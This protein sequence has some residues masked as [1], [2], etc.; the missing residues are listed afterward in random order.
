MLSIL[1]IINYI[2]KDEADQNII[3][4]T[5]RSKIIFGVASILKKMHNSNVIFRDVKLQKVGLGENL[6]STFFHN[7]L[8]KIVKD[9]S[10]MTQNIGT[11][12]VMAPEM[13]M[14]GADTYNFPIDVY[15]YGVMLYSMFVSDFKMGNKKISSKR[16]LKK[17][18]N[19]KRFD[20]SPKI[21]DHYWDLINECWEQDPNDRPTF[22]EIVEKL[23]SDKFA[24]EEFGIKTN[25]DELHEYQ[26]LI[27]N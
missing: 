5:I 6:E 4:P 21:P 15:S 9:P 27:D 20:K 24:L 22:D 2:C 23:K 10:Y 7:S 14:E 3:N 26:Q 19:G 16:I 1:I 17:V 12:F 18:A 8:T 11:T 25:L 13:F